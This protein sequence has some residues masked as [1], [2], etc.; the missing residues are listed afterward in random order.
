MDD[1]EKQ[2]FQEH[3][4]TN[5]SDAKFWT[6]LFSVV[7]HTFLFGGALLSAAAAAV[8]QFGD[9]QLSISAT[10]L[11]TVLAGAAAVTT[12]IAGS[13]GFERKWRTHRLIKVRLQQLEVDLMNPEVEGANI[14]Q[15]LKDIAQLRY[16]GI[17]GVELPQKPA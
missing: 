3:L 4:S 11:A 12:A 16:E 17:V 6:K 1:Q 14:R 9:L 13:G 7:H 15:D 10:N 2:N 8:L 5:L